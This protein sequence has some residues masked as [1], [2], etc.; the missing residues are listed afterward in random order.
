M[1]PEVITHLGE[2]KSFRLAKCGIA[3]AV[4]SFRAALTSHGLDEHFGVTQGTFKPWGRVG[5][6]CWG[7]PERELQP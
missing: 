2:G 5:C 1:P 4:V 7:D 6:E 3:P